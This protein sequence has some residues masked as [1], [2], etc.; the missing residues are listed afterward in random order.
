MNKTYIYIKMNNNKQ[1]K[2]KHQT[3]N[4]TNTYKTHNTRKNI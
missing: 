2:K 4:K 3:M 1:I